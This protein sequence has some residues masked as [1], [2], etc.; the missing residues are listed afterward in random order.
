MEPAAIPETVSGADAHVPYWRR[1][2]SVVRWLVV[3]VAVLC[4]GGTFKISD[5]FAAKSAVQAEVARA[6]V[7]AEL[8]ASNFRLEVEKFRLACVVLARDPDAQA[9]LAERGTEKLNALDQKFEQLS[10]EM[11]AAAIYLMSADGDTLAASNAGLPSTFVGSNYSFRTYFQGAMREGQ[12]EQFALGLSSHRP[13][14]YVAKRVDYM[15]SPLGV[16]VIKLEFDALESDWKHSFDLAFATNQKG[17]IL[18]TSVQSWRFEMTKQLTPDEQTRILQSL[19]FG[20]R[21]LTMNELF[22]TGQV[23]LAGSGRDLRRP[24]VE[25]VQALS[26]GWVVHVLVPTRAAVGTA[27]TSARFLVLSLILLLSALVGFLV[28]R[29]KNAAFQSERVI[30]ERL[31]VLNDRLVQ[32]N[33]LATIGQIAA[34]VGHEINQPLAAIASFAQNG[35]TFIKAGKWEN[36]GENL[37]RITE[38]TARIGAITSELRGFARKATGIS[39]HVSILDAINGA[40]LLLGDRIRTLGATVIVSPKAFDATVVAEEV[41]LEQVFVNLLQNALDASG[42]GARIRISL[43]VRDHMIEVGIADNGSGVSDAARASMFQP[44]FSSKRDGLG[45]GLVIS[46]DIMTDFGGELVVAS[47][48]QGALFIVRVRYAP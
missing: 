32:A 14:L 30:A 39:A 22:A 11:H 35:L 37:T 4:I 21:R 26:S 9:A 19:E 27:V 7:S 1:R 16:V 28:Y 18:V 44:F 12:Y 23:A 33:K 29:R 36:A 47:P 38:L 15:G 25:V 41:R 3:G 20:D 5:Y 10:R 2:A 42:K 40:L 17:I 13:G 8:L 6:H 24:Y 46:R 48:K 34:G 43:A 45:L 31:R